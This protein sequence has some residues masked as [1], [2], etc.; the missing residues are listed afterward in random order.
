MFAAAVTLIATLRLPRDPE[1][2]AWYANTPARIFILFSI[3]I[4]IQNFWTLSPDKHMELSILYTKYLLLFYLIHRLVDTPEQMRRFLIVNIA[5][6]AYLGW[7]G[8][9]TPVSGRLEG[10]GGPGID[11][12]NALAMHLGALLMVAAMS[13]LAERKK[14]FW[15]TLGALPFI[16][17][18]IVLA[19]SRGAFVAVLAGGVVLWYL[20]PR[21]YRTLFYTF[22]GLGVV[23]LGILAHEAFWER[24][25]TLKAAVDETEQMDASAESRIVLIRAQWQMFQRYPLGTGHR[26]TEVLSP[27]YIDQ[28][29]MSRTHDP[30]DTGRRSSHNTF[31]SALV[32]QGFPGAILF[33]SLW[34]WWVRAVLK[35][36]QFEQSMPP[37]L[38]AM[39]AG[40]AGALCVVFVAGMFVDYLKAEVQIWMFVLLLC[41]LEFARRPDPA[42]AAGCASTARSKMTSRKLS[43]RTVGTRHKLGRLMT[44]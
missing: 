7:L 15:L 40:I 19:G 42:A 41:A 1:R 28:S 33:A 34:L 27:L 22:A 17:N 11:E 16:V 3:W 36:K 43:E 37:R 8:Y 24:M 31:M 35:L 23:M 9:T 4:W 6:C 32:E 10:V 21:A 18:T 30:N 12:A 25:G 13:L 29:H 14:M 44:S 26:G 39:A 20:K 38:A 2:P 5:G